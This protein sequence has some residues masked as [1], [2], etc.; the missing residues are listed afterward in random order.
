MKNKRIFWGVITL[1]SLLAPFAFVSC[2]CNKK[3]DKNL[4]QENKDKIR[5]IYDSKFDRSLASSK[6]E[7]AL[8]ALSEQGF[9]LDK[10]TVVSFNDKEGILTIKVNG[11]F[12]GKEFL[13]FELK[14]EGFRKIEVIEGQPELTDKLNEIFVNEEKVESKADK[15]P[16]G[17]NALKNTSILLKDKK[18]AANQSKETVNNL[19][20]EYNETK[21]PAKLAELTAA[22]NELDKQ[23]KEYEKS[24]KEVYDDMIM[25]VFGNV[26][27]ATAQDTF[28]NDKLL[29]EDYKK[30]NYNGNETL[31]YY[32]QMLGYTKEDEKNKISSEVEPIITK[33]WEE[34]EKK[35]FLNNPNV[36]IEEL[37]TLLNESI[38]FF[39]NFIIQYYSQFSE[40]IAN[41]ANLFEPEG[42]YFNLKAHKILEDFLNASKIEDSTKKVE[43]L[44]NAFISLYILQDFPSWFNASLSKPV[45]NTKL[46][47]AETTASQFID[48]YKKDLSLLV[49][50]SREM[51]ADF[52]GQKE[53]FRSEPYDII[54]TSKQSGM[55]SVKYKVRCINT[56]DPANPNDIENQLI[57]KE[58]EEE[59]FGF[60]AE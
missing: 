50:E 5:A 1:S 56:I 12:K 26:L 55:I 59:I 60:K 7:D 21:E 47:I 51:E 32:L 18:D 23:N 10:A 11:K 6:N 8:K 58:I 30:L 31:Y 36:T 46:N 49:F 15:S 24:V 41:F 44:K 38:K 9:E 19:I 34:V 4:S 20:K 25:F 27:N 54:V 53:L 35:L 52:L 40:S 16:L 13:E 39:D 57:S 37:E 43:Y 45:I 42:K 28:V 29:Y 2:S 3:E 33:K 14:F 17:Y 48:L 22:I